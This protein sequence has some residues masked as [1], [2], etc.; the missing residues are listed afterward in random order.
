MSVLRGN[1]EQIITSG[2]QATETP[3]VWVLGWVVSTSQVSKQNPREVFPKDNPGNFILSII[4]LLRKCL[5]LSI[6]HMILLQ[7]KDQVACVRSNLMDSTALVIGFENFSL[8]TP[9]VKG[10]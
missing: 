2:T 3:S 5:K 4:S 10:K 8:L 9:Q 1:K 6:I 7:G